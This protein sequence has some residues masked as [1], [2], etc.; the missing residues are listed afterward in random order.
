MLLL[1]KIILLVLCA[2]G[3]P[4]LARRLFPATVLSRAIDNGMVLSDQSPLLGASKTWRGIIAS[5][6]LTSLLALLMGLTLLDGFLIAVFAMSGDLISSFIKRRLGYPVSSKVTV[7]D[8]VPESLLP[9]IYVTV[10]Y[11]LP[12]YYPVLGIIAFFILELLL[13]KILYKWGVRKHPY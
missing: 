6:F 13:S 9:W 7:L 5:L 4:I 2:N 12:L 11:Q 3:A 1:L 8:Q 10:T